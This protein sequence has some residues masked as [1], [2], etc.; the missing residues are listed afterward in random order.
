M[1]IAEFYDWAIAHPD[2]EVIGSDGYRYKFGGK[3][4]MY[5]NNLTDSWWYPTSEFDRTFTIPE[6]AMIEVDLLTAMNWSEDHDNAAFKDSLNKFG[7]TCV[8]GSLITG[9]GY[10][11]SVNKSLLKAKYLIP[12]EQVK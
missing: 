4:F 6:P 11:V 5:R 9:V 10:H 8:D 7:Y 1:N 12:E 3:T 2:E